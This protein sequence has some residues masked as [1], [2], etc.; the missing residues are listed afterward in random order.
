[1]LLILVDFAIG[2]L[3]WF[4]KRYRYKAGDGVAI[5]G[6]MGEGELFGGNE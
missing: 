6:G 3:P 2:L 4:K 1:M 5:T